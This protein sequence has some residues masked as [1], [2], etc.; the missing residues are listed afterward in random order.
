MYILGYDLNLIYFVLGVFTVIMVVFN[1]IIEHFENQLPLFIVEA[2]RYGKTLNGP[3]QTKIVRFIKVPK[4]W[5]LHFYIFSSIY[6]SLLLITAYRT[7]INGAKVPGVVFDGL[8]L[9]CTESRTEGSSK[10]N[11]LLALVLLMLQC[12]RRF[13]ECAFVNAKSNSSMNILHY[14]VGYAHYFC[15]GTGI[16]CQAP[17]F[18][19]SSEPVENFELGKVVTVKNCV[20]SFVFFWSMWHQLRAHKIFAE[21][22]V[23]N[24]NKH[25]IPHGDLFELVSCPHYF[26]EVL[27]YTS[28]SVILG[29]SHS[30]ILAVWLWVVVN[31]TVA[32]F[33]SHSWYNKHFQDYPKERRAIYPYLL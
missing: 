23:K 33:M 21:L 31:Q 6:S 11:I 22:K 2:F 20:A 17:E 14:I 24:P 15:T 12:S 16:L 9:V 32:A 30:H 25:G 13:Y 28:L 26:C 29:L 27:I 10:E 8:D 18:I 4:S 3:V 1:G 5:F 7:C 19:S